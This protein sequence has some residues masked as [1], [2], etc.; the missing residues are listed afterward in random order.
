MNRAQAK[1]LIDKGFTAEEVKTIYPNFNRGCFDIMK[2]FANGA[3]LDC[4]LADNPSFTFDACEY[5]IKPETYTM[6][7]VECPAPYRVEPEVDET[8]YYAKNDGSIDSYAWCDGKLDY[9]FFKRGK[10]FKTAEDARAT[11]I[12]IWGEL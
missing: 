3:E 10:C 5:Q 1:L 2:Q 6:N 7:G 4:H 8:Y 11:D 9:T 12:A